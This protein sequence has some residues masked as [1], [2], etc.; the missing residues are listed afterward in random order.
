MQSHGIDNRAT[1]T[2]KIMDRLQLG[3]IHEL[4]GVTS[5]KFQKTYFI[6]TSLSAFPSCILWLPRVEALVMVSF[7]DFV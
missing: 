6:D 5:Q 1:C 3:N 4:F 2:I 7:W